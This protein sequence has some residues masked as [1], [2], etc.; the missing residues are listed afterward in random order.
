MK[1]IVFGVTLL[2]SVAISTWGGALAQCPADT[3]A[4]MRCDSGVDENGAFFLIVLPEKNWNGKLILWNHGYSL[5]PPTALRFQDLGPAG[6][7]TSLGFAAAASSYRP[8]AIGLGGWAVREG[9]E[10]TDRLR[11]RFE[12][13]FGRPQYTYIIGA[14][15]GGLVT[16]TMM[17]LYGRNSDG[18]LRYD[19]AMPMCGPLAGARRNWYGGLDLRV[20]YQ[21]YCQ[22]LPRPDEPPYDL[23]LGLHPENRLIQEEVIGRVNECTG[24]LLP[25]DQRT[26]AQQRNLDN[27]LGVIRIPQSFITTDILFATFALQE[28]TLV[29]MGGRNPLTNV[30]VQYTGSDDDE[31]LNAGVTRWASDPEA[32]ELLASSYDPQGTISAPVLTIHTIG[33]GL[34]IVENENAYLETLREAGTDALL[35]QNY[36]DAEGHCAFSFAEILAPFHALRDWVEK[37]VRPTRQSVDALC[38]DVYQPMFG[39]T[40]NLNLDF[41]P[42][43]FETRVPDRKP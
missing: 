19:G 41:E 40:C 12:I 16:A 28:L 1:R 6:L 25:P 10:D 37:G 4:G 32:V 3:P 2:V 39:G 21:Y 5:D 17:E 23:Y 26:E 43:A 11:R 35:Q 9:A 38:R 8:D 18:S 24:F 29:R 34:V 7:T 22:N 42:A 30:G 36:V 27:I 33:D 31:A 14:S 15:E 20:V 13:L